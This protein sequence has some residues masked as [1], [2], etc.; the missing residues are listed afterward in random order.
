MYF[1]LALTLLIAAS[2]A[3]IVLRK[4]G[5]IRGRAKDKSYV[6]YADFERGIEDLRR[7]FRHSSDA[8]QAAT[9]R[10]TTIGE[11]LI[12]IIKPI[13]LALRDLNARLI[14]VEQQANETA[15]FVVG[16]QKQLSENNGR[17]SI[18]TE[19]LQQ[20]LIAVTDQLSLLEQM[21]EIVKGRGES[22]DTATEAINARLADIQSQIDGL[23]PRLELGEK[24]RADLSTL[25]NSLAEPLKTLTISS[26][27]VAERIADLEQRFL[28]M[29]T[30]FEARL[31]AAEHSSATD[32][33]QQRLT[34]VT[35]QL[36]SL[37][38]MIEVVKV[39]RESNDNA[40]EAIN[41]R[42]VDILNLP[43]FA[44]G[45]LV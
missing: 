11:N 44:G 41:V 15:T 12:S 29:A 5:L 27:R 39:R 28:L 17:I 40:T 30:E 43:G 33:F 14:R 23:F 34:A 4:R 20:R 9:R 8:A 13:E 18:Q 38:Q 19:T 22:N 3:G 10:A 35:E 24:E 21:I 16:L 26:E 32:A 1:G 7:E 6:G 45:C 2:A 37:E 42:L 31:S 36:S 25:H